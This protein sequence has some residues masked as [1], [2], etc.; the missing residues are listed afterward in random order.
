MKDLSVLPEG[1]EACGADQEF[2]LYRRSQ[3]AENTRVTVMEENRNEDS[4]IY[5][6]KI[7]SPGTWRD[8]ILSLDFGGDKIEVFR[9]G[10]MAH[11]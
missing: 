2:T 10:E 11:R 7:T 1:F 6:L 4:R 5:D 9:N 8:T 3:K